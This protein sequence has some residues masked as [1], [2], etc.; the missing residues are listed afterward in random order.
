MLIQ[1]QQAGP[2]RRPF[3]PL[4]GRPCSE[5]QA[6]HR[7]RVNS[8][9]GQRWQAQQ[10]SR[11]GSAEVRRRPE[12]RVRLSWS[13]LSFLAGGVSPSPSMSTR[14]LLASESFRALSVTSAFCFFRGGPPASG[15]LE[16]LGGGAAGGGDKTPD[17]TF[18]GPF[19]GESAGRGMPESSYTL[20]FTVAF[21]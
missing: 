2:P 5:S 4:S 21:I 18:L 14:S 3:C 16:L 11:G 8:D 6:V 13:K 17:A 7:S 12:S 20:R 10:E 9:R 15:A 19:L 1:E